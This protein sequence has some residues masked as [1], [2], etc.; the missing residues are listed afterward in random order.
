MLPR[1][2]PASFVFA[3]VSMALVAV[4]ITPPSWAQSWQTPVG[5]RGRTVSGLPTVTSSSTSADRL[6]GSTPSQEVS[7]WGGE[8]FNGGLYVPGRGTYVSFFRLPPGTTS[9]DRVRVCFDHDG[10]PVDDLVYD[11]VFFRDLGKTPGSLIRRIEGVRPGRV[12]DGATCVDSTSLGVPELPLR[13]DGEDLFFGIRLESIPEIFVGFVSENGS[14]TPSYLRR[15]ND[16]WTRMDGPT[17][18]TFAFVLE[19][20]VG[21]PPTHLTCPVQ[22]CTTTAD[23]VCLG[24]R[25][26]VTASFVDQGGGSGPMA[27]TEYRNDTGIAHF[28]DPDN[29]ELM[30]KVLDACT[31]NDRFWVFA[32]GLTDQ[33]IDLRIC[34]TQ[35]GIETRYFSPLKT[36]F[37]PITDVDAFATCPTLG[38]P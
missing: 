22:P 34:D 7:V 19:V 31:I 4:G 35:S 36:P 12:I 11:L 18:E 26:L 16:P 5:S 13:V 14:S 15:F 29:A 10:Q 33:E 23:Q 32:G 27:W 2:R 30:V 25:F 3:T 9:I 8:V 1:R 24:E 6:V 20:T 28:N 37:R 38:S 17:F 21:E